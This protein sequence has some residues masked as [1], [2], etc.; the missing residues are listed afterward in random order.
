VER[1]AV[2]SDHA[3]KLPMRV[4]IRV[5]YSNS[6]FEAGGDPTYIN[7]I[8]DQ[9]LAL[10]ESRELIFILTGK[11]LYENML[12]ERLSTSTDAKTENALLL[13]VE[14][15]EIIVVDTV[16][17]QLAPPQNQAQPGNT[18]GVNEGGAVAAT[19][20]TNVNQAAADATFGAPV[21]TVFGGRQ[22]TTITSGATNTAT[23]GNQTFNTAMTTEIPIQ[24]QADSSGSNS[25]ANAFP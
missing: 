4:I 19:Q 11:R 6:S 25:L 16:V 17:T 3:F 24:N 12:I 14:C 10:Q 15:R 2:I 13:A 23:V 8:Y 7:D 21:T 18:S 22:T 9:F 1:N 20:A 5:G